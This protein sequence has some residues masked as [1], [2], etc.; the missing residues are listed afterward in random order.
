[1]AGED[2]QIRHRRTAPPEQV[3]V[4]TL[5][6]LVIE[7]Y[8]QNGQKTLKHAK[9]QIEHSLLPFFGEMPAGEVDSDQIESGSSGVRAVDSASQATPPS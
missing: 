5:L 1:M 4:G 6:D 2:S 3:T 9:G 8:K 7:D